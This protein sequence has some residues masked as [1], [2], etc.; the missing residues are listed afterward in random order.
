MQIT[1][2]RFFVMVCAIALVMPSCVSKKKFEE[3]MNEKGALAESLAASQ[4]KVQE[5]DEKIAQLESD[6]DAQKK[7]FEGRIASLESDLTAAKSEAEAAKAATAAKEAEI[8]SL[9]TQV[10]E[11]FA[12]TGDL[13][14]T[15]KNGA[16]VVSLE[17]PV[18]YKS[19][20]S[21]LDKDARTAIDNLAEMMKN[22]PDMS[23]LIEGHTDDK[24]FISGSR[25]NWNLSIDRATK[26]VRR[27]I[28]KGVNSSQLAIVGRGDTMPAAS[29]ETE[30]GRA[31]NRRTE[32]KPNVSTGS[33][34][35][36]GGN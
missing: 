8:T 20:S 25:D 17:N 27:L 22:N 4:K 14:L 1:T 36:I 18:N 19:G 15:E 6:M 7:D 9:K 26:V 31:E 2:L 34:F 32:V 16:M 29:N 11:A 13:T 33:L 21:R 12:V 10:K 30:E 5:L 3:L 23:L 28:K 24:A 35:K